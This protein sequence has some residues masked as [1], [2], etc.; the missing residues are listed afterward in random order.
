[1]SRFRVMP[2]PRAGEAP[3]GRN[4]GLREPLQSGSVFRLLA[5]SV[6][7]Y[8]IFMLT[9]EGYIASWNPGAERIKQYKAE[10]IIGKHF[11]IF[12]PS[13]DLENDKPGMEL[14]VA[15]ETGR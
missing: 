15:A 3:L 14:R 7:D 4:A 2:V 11:S 9:P 1:M 12:Y 8:A 6:R 10:E 13:K 5:E